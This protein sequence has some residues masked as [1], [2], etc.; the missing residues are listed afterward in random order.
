MNFFINKEEFNDKQT[1][2]LKISVVCLIY[3]TIQLC[4]IPYATLAM[5][6]FWLAY[7]TLH[8]KIG[9]PYRDF[10][11][12]KTVLG[13]YIFLIPMTLFHGLLSPLLYTKVW[14]ALINTAFLAG[15]SIWL[16]KFYSQKAILISLAFIIFTPLFLR[17][18]ADIRVDLLAY[19]LCLIS[20]ILLLD[21]AYLLAGISIAVGFLICQ[22]AAWYIIATNL[23]LLGCWLSSER[24]WKM[25]R[26]I[27]TFNI[28]MLLTVSIYIIFWSYFSNLKTVL[29]S[30]F[31]EAYLI[32][33]ADFYIDTRIYFWNLIINNNPGFTLLW[34]FA[35]FGILILPVK[36]NIFIFIYSS[37]IIFFVTSCKQPFLYY[38]LAAI[39]A[40][41]IL[42]I[43]FF[44]AVYNAA[45]ISYLTTTRKNLIVIFSIFYITA[46]IFLYSKLAFNDIYLISA[47]IP[48]LLC[49]IIS[50]SISADIKSAF[51]SIIYYS[52]LLIGIIFPLLHFVITLP[53]MNGHYQKSMI[54]LMDN[55]LSDGGSYIAGVPLLRDVE[56][57]VPG[58]IHLVGPS[59]EYINHPSKKLFPIIK[60]HSMYLTPTT[61]PEI[62]DT[63]KTSP[64]KLYVDNDRFHAL[65]KNLHTFLATE[66]QHYWGSIYLYAPTIIAGHRNVKIK[67]TGNYKVKSQTDIMLNNKKMIANS[68][69]HLNKQQ[70][71]SDAKATYRLQL[72]PDPVKNLLE[73]NYKN[74]NWK[75]M[76]D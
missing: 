65:S 57:P 68:I 7:H 48:I 70:Y 20:L 27:Y 38:P 61:V 66:Y 23:G 45:S 22:K 15:I 31:Y 41:F 5:D 73:P 54:Y 12:Y 28:S 71:V 19:W 6:D 75:I 43:T 74:S 62:I 52:T 44:S 25:T 11:P 46:L 67:F 60:L 49:A 37:V 69:I 76:L 18:S 47:L 40:L 72:T 4:Y 1:Y 17:Y 33:S 13:Y 36:H 56:Q 14:I 29:D 42:Y 21:E 16:K 2:V 50:N 10:A 24:T 8:Y 35:L 9:L 58:L 53:Y 30:V 59:I 26:N 55:L 51:I 39:P 3:I 64:V 34:P 63:I 32:T